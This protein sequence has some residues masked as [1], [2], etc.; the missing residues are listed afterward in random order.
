LQQRGEQKDKKEEKAG[1]AVTIDD[2]QLK[3]AQKMIEADNQVQSLVGVENI[4][5]HLPAAE[6]KLGQVIEAMV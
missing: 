6:Y 5:E 2:K 1:L 3:L 4:C